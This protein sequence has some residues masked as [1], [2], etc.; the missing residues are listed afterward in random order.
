MYI[1]YISQKKKKT[2]KKKFY[3]YITI[4]HQQSLPKRFFYD[5]IY[6]DNKVKVFKS[7]RYFL[8]SGTPADSILDVLGVLIVG[9]RTLFQPKGIWILI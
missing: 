4:Y 1:V 8:N 7:L 3:N 2:R 6:G 9:L 5:S